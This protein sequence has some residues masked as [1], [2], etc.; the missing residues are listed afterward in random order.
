MNVSHETVELS[1][2]SPTAI[3]VNRQ[4]AVQY[5]LSFTV[6]NVDESANVYIGGAGVSSI[7]Y[8][9]KLVPGAIVSFENVSRNSAFFAI[10][11]SDGSEVAIL[12]TSF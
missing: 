7:S 9:I 5:S 11:D 10:T 4:D 6:Q 2:G 12:Q 3:P 8:G 1:D